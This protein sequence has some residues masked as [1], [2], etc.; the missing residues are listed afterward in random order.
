LEGVIAEY[1]AIK[2]EVGLLRQLVE[3]STATQDGEREDG[4]FGGGGRSDDDNVGSASIVPHELERIEEEVEE[5][6]A[7]QERQRQQE[8]ERWR[9]WVSQAQPST[10]EPMGLGITHH[11]PLEDD[12]EP[13]RQPSSPDSSSLPPPP[14]AWHPPMM[15]PPPLLH[16]LA[17]Q[18]Q[19]RQPSQHPVD[20]FAAFLEGDPRQH[21]G[22]AFRTIDWPVHVPIQDGRP[23][24]GTFPSITICRSSFSD[25]LVTRLDLTP[26]PP[27]NMSMQICSPLW[28]WGW[29]G[30][31]ILAARSAVWGTGTPIGN[32]TTD[33]T[34]DIDIIQAVFVVERKWS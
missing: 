28:G 32:E 8:D 18:Q 5:Q 26:P 12:E 25:L 20:L 1:D 2:R 17:Q 15:Y 22:P 31:C 14:P 24:T 23:E 33:W 6:M 3:K 21:G 7:G 9:R 27:P 4:D 10:R 11:L 19:Q 34:V 29:R 30:W 16:A 13:H